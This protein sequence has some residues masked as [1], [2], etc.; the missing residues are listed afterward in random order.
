M[1]S[2]SRLAGAYVTP[3]ITDQWYPARLNTW[4]H[5][6]QSG[7]MFLAWRGLSHTVKEFWPEIRRTLP[8]K[9]KQ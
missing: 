4:D 3:M 7:S 8:F 6:L 9:R 5:K 2:V 1:I